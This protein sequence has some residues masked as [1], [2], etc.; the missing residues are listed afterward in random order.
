VIFQ[1]VTAASGDE[2][3]VGVG[4]E[5]DARQPDDAKQRCRDAAIRSRSS[6]QR[7]ATATQLTK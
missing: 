3:R 7:S 1:M 2:G 4:Q 5:P 6:T